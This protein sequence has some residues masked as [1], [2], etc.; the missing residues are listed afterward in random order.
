MI[1]IQRIGLDMS[2]RRGHVA[3]RPQ[4]GPRP[5]PRHAVAGHDRQRRD[6][7]SPHHVPAPV[8]R[9]RQDAA[10][11]R[12]RHHDDAPER[13]ST[14][15]RN[16]GSR[17]KP[18]DVWVVNNTPDPELTLTA[19]HPKGSAE[20]R[21]VIKAKLVVNQ[22]LE[23]IS[24]AKP[25]K[26]GAGRERAATSTRSRRA[27]PDR[28]RASSRASS[29]ASSPRL[30]GLAWWWAFR[31]WRHPRT[32]LIGVAVLPRR[33]VPVL[34]V[35]GTRASRRLLTNSR[36]GAGRGRGGAHR[37]VRASHT[38]AAVARARRVGRRDGVRQGRAPAA[39]RRVQVPRCDERGAVAVGRRTRAAA[40]PRIRRAITRPR[41]A[42]AATARAASPRTS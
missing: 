31:R 37:A 27:C 14:R 12:H 20:Y 11:R 3:R 4:E 15:S 19:C 21:I 26:P 36:P 18:T 39:H 40:S 16:R 38:G 17:S 10:R 25:I 8:R 35:P 2:L 34:R 1:S 5:L 9:P 22:E 23:A 13:S 29:S 24:I 41:C 30:V 42:R 33:A 6:R 28:R 32:W 7:R